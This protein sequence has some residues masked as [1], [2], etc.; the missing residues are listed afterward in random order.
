MAIDKG[1]LSIVIIGGVLNPLDILIVGL[2]I[3]ARR[4]KHTPLKLSDYLI[5][6]G[7]VRLFTMYMTKMDF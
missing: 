2:R 3:W 5:I 1:G 4:I 7:E 6:V